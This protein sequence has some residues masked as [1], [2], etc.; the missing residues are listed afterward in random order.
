M[1]LL[2]IEES[3]LTY[4]QFAALRA[5]PELR[6][7]LFTRLGGVSQP[8]YASLN[9]GSSVG[10]DRASV[11]EN[12]RRCVATLGFQVG[13]VVTAFQVHSSTVARVDRRDAGRVIPATDGL[14]TDA[15]GI[16]LVLRFADCVPILLYDAEHAALGLAH[17][18]WRGTLEG[19]A[20]RA[21]SAMQEHF[22][23]RP[24]RL[25]AGIGPAIGPCC[26]QVGADL[27]DAFA[28]RFGEQAVATNGAG[29]VV[30][31]PR[32]NALALEEAGLQEIEIAGLCT[33]CHTGEFFSHRAEGGRTGRQPALIGLA[34]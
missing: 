4:Y 18:G 31:L 13:Q 22:G 11:A 17:A 28:R 30:D 3:G 15:R 32:A 24:E 27:R 9:V 5:V 20:A 21:V 19:I 6:H 23:S 12:S 14:V 26:Y 29:P 16:V 25:W 7:G 1:T 8:P 34:G 10:D 33:A 2:R